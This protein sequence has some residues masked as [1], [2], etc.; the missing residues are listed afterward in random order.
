LKY[1]KQADSAGVLG[2]KWNT[3]GV[4]VSDLVKHLHKYQVR[5]G[6]VSNGDDAAYGSL[7]RGLLAYYAAL[8]QAK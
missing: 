3:V 6:R 4:N 5:F 8:S 7:H 1:L 2:T